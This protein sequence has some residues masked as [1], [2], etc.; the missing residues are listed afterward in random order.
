MDQLKSVHDVL[1]DL[2]TQ[3][4]Y[5]SRSTV[6]R[7]EI[8]T[9]F[10]S[11]IETYIIDLSQAIETFQELEDELEEAQKEIEWLKNELGE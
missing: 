9:E 2:D 1:N 4:N 6:E 8:V 5:R 7:F 3:I 10:L 11:N